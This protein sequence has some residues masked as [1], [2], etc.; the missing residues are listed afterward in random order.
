M[1][2]LLITALC[3]SSFFC[4]SQSKKINVEVGYVE[5]I[6]VTFL[7]TY[8]RSY[9]TLFADNTSS[10]YKI[11]GGEV[12]EGQSF[13]KN[14]S[15]F[16]DT[17]KKN[18]YNDY[19]KT[20]LLNKKL[21]FFELMVS[22]E[23]L[24]EDIYPD[25]RW[26][27]TEEQKVIADYTCVKATV[28]YRGRDWTAWFTPEI[29]LAVGPWKLHGLPGL[30]LEAYDATGECTYKAINIAFKDNSI[31]HSDFTKLV[32]TKNKKPI[33]YRQFLEDRREALENITKKTDMDSPNVMSADVKIPRFGLELKYEWEQ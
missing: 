20:D 29:P 11:Y 27:I 13:D 12:S 31:L 32:K 21:L 24:V 25:L 28:S 14:D 18:F 26:T 15:R 30:I 33:T 7:N 8:G 23:V 16:V 1:K 3:I 2:I 6:N 17:S 22:N 4:F 9:S 5:F 19:I 10:I